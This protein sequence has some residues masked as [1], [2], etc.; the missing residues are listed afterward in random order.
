MLYIFY[1]DANGYLG[2]FMYDCGIT[3]YQLFFI[4]NT[5]LPRNRI[6][7]HILAVDSGT[8]PSK[9]LLKC[10]LLMFEGYLFRNHELLLMC[11][12]FQIGA[13]HYLLVSLV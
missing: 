10:G 4:S 11:P 5:Q 2:Y 3:I 12:L 13:K 6:E 1:G 7:L 9:K 8:S